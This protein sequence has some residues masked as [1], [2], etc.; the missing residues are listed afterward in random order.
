MSKRK[1][2]YLPLG[3]ISEGTMV[4]EDVGDALVWELS[5]LRLSREHRKLVR[6]WDKERERLDKR[7][8]AEQWPDVTLEDLLD[9]LWDAVDDYAPPY[10][11][12]G[13]LE[14][15]GACYGVWPDIEYLERNSCNVTL[16]A[17]GDVVKVND[18]AELASRPDLKK[19]VTFS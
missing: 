7:A 5:Q 14:G 10:C 12:V 18:L 3:T 13:A 8:D 2:Q 19:R 15:D 11:Y 4:T 9:E 6:E 16:A 17:M 1:P